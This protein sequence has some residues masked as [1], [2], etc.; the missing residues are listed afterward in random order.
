MYPFLKRFFL[1]TVI[2]IIDFQRHWLQRQLKA[3]FEC[4]IQAS[5]YVPFV[6]AKPKPNKLD[7]IG[8]NLISP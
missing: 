8:S 1:E 4:L 7:M 2:E 6:V 5:L 3:I